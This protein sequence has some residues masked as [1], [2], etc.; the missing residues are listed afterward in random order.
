MLNV[1]VFVDTSLFTRSMSMFDSSAGSSFTFCRSRLYNLIT[2]PSTITFMRT[3]KYKDTNYHSCKF[4]AFQ[5]VQST[6]YRSRYFQWK[7]F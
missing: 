3:S 5:D 6:Q 7:T 1:N 2:C 4:C